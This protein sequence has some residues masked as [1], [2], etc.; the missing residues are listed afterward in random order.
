MEDKKMKTE[1]SSSEKLDTTKVYG[2]LSLSE[3]EIYQIAE[4]YSLAENLKPAANKYEKVLALILS[5]RQKKILS[6]LLDDVPAISKMPEGALDLWTADNSN[7]TK[8]WNSIKN[9]MEYL[10]RD[11]NTAV[12]ALALQEEIGTL[13]RQI[14]DLQNQKP[15]EQ[16]ISIEK[17]EKS[18]DTAAEKSADLTANIILPP[19]SITDVHLV[20]IHALERFVEYKAD[21]NIAFLL[22]GLFAGAAVS[23]LVN[24]ATNET[25]A[26]NEMSS[27][28]L[29]FFIMLA[30]LSIGWLARISSRIK[31]VSDIFQKNS[32][33]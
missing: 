8:Y 15:D 17:I 2:L 30:L 18:I 16:N 26:P 29:I 22:I 21:E 27:T 12:N 4:K 20:P 6:E 31:K 3:E 14:K 28:L 1:S 9:K 23:I 33:K 19:R 10:E 11:R 24:W 25:F 32:D 13:R 7:L 5:A